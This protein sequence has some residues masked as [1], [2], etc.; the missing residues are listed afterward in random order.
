MGWG[1]ALEEEE[2]CRQGKDE[3]CKFTDVSSIKTGVG[4]RGLETALEGPLSNTRGRVMHQPVGPGILS[5]ALFLL[6]RHV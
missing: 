6:T 1:Q 5:P 3:D 2:R 4:Q